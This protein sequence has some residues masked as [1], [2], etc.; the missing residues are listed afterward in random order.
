MQALSPSVDGDLKGFQLVLGVTFI[1]TSLP[2]IKI[3][4]I[5]NNKNK[6]IFS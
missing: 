3:S 1:G 6:L 5:S 4:V 2:S